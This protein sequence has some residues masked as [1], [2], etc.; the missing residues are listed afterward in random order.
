LDHGI[1][2]FDT[3]DIYGQGDSE[4]ALGELAASCR[5]GLIIMSK[6]GYRFGPIGSPGVRVKALIRSAVRMLPG[7]KRLISKARASV[8]R[9]DFSKAYLSEAIEGSLRRLR[10]DFLDVFLLHSPPRST[11]ESDEPFDLLESFKTQGKI[12]YYGVS[13]Q[14]AEDAL[15]C[16]KRPTI[17]VIQVR[18][19]PMD[20]QSIDQVLP[21]ARESRIAVVAREVF[22]NGGVFTT[23]P[24]NSCSASGAG[25]A[26]A[27]TPGIPQSSDESM[28]RMALRFVLS[29]A[30]VSLA[31]VGTTNLLHLRESIAEI[32]MPFLSKVA[33]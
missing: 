4:R 11:V 19:N 14:T 3:A 29:Q 12:R 6:A 32:Q 25:S 24:A 18:I 27:E 15:A 1:N 8:G 9:Q 26:N 16:L 28:A 5:Q 23:R 22:A 17:S 20:R 21:R 33:H 2:V 10:R 30:G 7:S 13:C 31:L